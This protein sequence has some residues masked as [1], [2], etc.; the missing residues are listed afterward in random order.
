MID[1]LDWVRSLRPPAPSA[2]SE[3]RA[4]ALG[5]LE[6]AIVELTS[7]DPNVN[8]RVA[9]RKSSPESAGT[10]RDAGA[11]GHHRRADRPRHGLS[12]RLGWL[13]PTMAAIVALVIAGGVLVLVRHGSTGA[14]SSTGS[15]PR[16]LILDRNGTALV[17]NQAVYHL[18][19]NLGE[20]PAAAAARVT[21]YRLLFGTLYARRLSRCDA[22][23]H[24][25]QRLTVPECEL[26]ARR[27]HAG[28]MTLAA[29][30]APR[31]RTFVADHKA[32]LPGVSIARS[33]EREYPFGTL[34]A[35]LFG[36]V[37][38]ITAREAHEARYQGVPATATVGQSG[39]EYEY[40]EYLR[41]GQNLT[42]T[43]DTQ[44]ERAGSRALQ[45]AI[46]RN[47]H[48]SGGAFVAMNPE[49]GEVYG[50]GSLPTFNANVFTKPISAAEYNHLFGPSAGSPQLNRAI[51]SAGP[52]GSTFKPITATAALE[53][54]DWN[55]NSSYD[56]TGQFCFPGTT[57]CLHNSGHAA[58][59]TVNLVQ[60]IKVSDDIFFYNLG[61]R[62]NVDAPNGGPLQKWAKAFG[63]G[64]PTGVD[65]PDEASGTLPTPAWRANRNKLES[66]CEQAIGP[67]KGDPKHPAAD[68]GC[69][70]AVTPPEQWT[71]GDNVNMAVGQGDVQVTPLQLAVAY[72]ALANGG[73]IVRPHVGLDIQDSDGTVLQKIQPPPARHIDINPLYRQTILEGLREA[74]SQPGGT[75]ADVF[76]NFPEQVYGKTGTAQ[77]ITDGV[78]QDY[79]WYACFV[80][81][82]ATSKPIAV[83]V[84]VQQGGFGAVAAAPVAREI[85]SQWFL[86]KP[87][88]YQAGTS[89]TL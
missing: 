28:V 59:G 30:V 9:E 86:G 33:Y 58:Q 46:S 2:R 38:P 73:T 10:S 5:D 53:S 85:L 62:T 34:A 6:S 70:I 71:I 3:V 80:P 43:L 89:T 75:S 78:E 45:Q 22:A 50:M 84:W 39:L 81:A 26:A 4:A 27:G 57:D 60:A 44:L 12:L 20:L 8:A 68:G 76:G 72:S 18:Q 23:G 55:V 16:G 54:G 17:K 7:S 1:E 31:V 61:A 79:A 41:A 24:R 52:T 42:T 11:S 36:I 40:D 37:G 51:Q 88:P 69:G 21:E 56:D 13:M 82:S 67:Y 35:Q 63:I 49:N 74:A 47:P 65:L 83:V 77:Y 64:Q 48:A 29:D 15:G 14:G 87:G 66:E 19:I 25:S 32:E